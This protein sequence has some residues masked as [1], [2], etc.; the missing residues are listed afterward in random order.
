[1]KRKK[2]IGNPTTTPYNQSRKVTVREVSSTDAS[3][4]W[5]IATEDG[6]ELFGDVFSDKLTYNDSIEHKRGDMM[7]VKPKALAKPSVL[8]ICTIS[9][10]HPD[11]GYINTYEK[12][13]TTEYVEQSLSTLREITDEKIENAEQAIENAEQA[14]ENAEQAKNYQYTTVDMTGLEGQIWLS[15]SEITYAYG[16]ITN[17]EGQH[18]TLDEI[19]T[20]NYVSEETVLILDLTTIV[21]TPRVSISHGSSVPIKWFDGEP[22]EVEAGKVYMFSFVRAK[23]SDNTPLFY[24]GIGGEFV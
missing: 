17:Q 24:L 23:T 7:T 10:Y 16:T 3:L 19:A 2:I 12:P 6:E 4:K 15:P 14:I 20:P 21:G 18:F 8:Y 13:A 22:P 11:Y 1:M 5:S 9:T